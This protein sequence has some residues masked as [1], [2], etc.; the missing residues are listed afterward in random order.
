M[1]RIPVVDDER[2]ISMLVEDRL[3]E[4]GCGVVGL[5]RTVA[6]WPALAVGQ[7]DGAI[8]DVN[9]AGDTC[10]PL[11]NALRSRGVPVASAAGDGALD[12]GQG[13]KDALILRKP[14]DFEGVKSVL[15]KMLS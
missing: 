3:G 9:L 7:L 11:A 2:L 12:E 14:Y 4:L 6:D 10:F 13:F 5:A 8:F 15:G 1:P